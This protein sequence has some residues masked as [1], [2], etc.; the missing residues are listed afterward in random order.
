M[1]AS[2]STGA[3]SLT[4]SM[5]ARPTRQAIVC[6]GSR[7]APS[8]IHRALARSGHYLIALFG[9][10]R[11]TTIVRPS[12]RL[13]SDQ[14][15]NMLQERRWIQDGS[16]AKLRDAN[17]ITRAFTCPGERQLVSVR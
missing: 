6:S 15:L 11:S 7:L 8:T 13:T 4:E 5:P 14:S 12:D 16:I 10:C 1:A 2:D 9:H 17:T 3:L